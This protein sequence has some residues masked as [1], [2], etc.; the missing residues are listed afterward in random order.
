MTVFNSLFDLTRD[1]LLFANNG[2]A[3]AFLPPTDLIVSDTEVT[4]AM[5]VPGLNANS[6]EIEL[7][8][9]VLTSRGERQHPQL[10]RQSTQWYR[11]ERGYG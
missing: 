8:G 3:R 6:L 4:V 7:T 2:T 10:D 1:G 9:D 5:D 11:I